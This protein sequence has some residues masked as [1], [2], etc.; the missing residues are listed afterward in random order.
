MKIVKSI[1]AVIAAPVV[2]GVL[3]VGLTSALLAVF[4]D[5]VNEQGGTYHLVMTL[6]VEAIQFRLRG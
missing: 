1:L 5:L 6:T 3:G 4:P 2:Y